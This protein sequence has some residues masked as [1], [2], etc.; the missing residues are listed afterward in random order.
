MKKK[1]KNSNITKEAEAQM[2]R[3]LEKLN[4][5]YEENRPKIDEKI[6]GTTEMHGIYI[7]TSH[8]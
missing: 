7:G 4:G 1:E 2:A 6:G 3:N 5:T 8:R